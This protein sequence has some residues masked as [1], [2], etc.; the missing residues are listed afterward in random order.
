[1]SKH[2]QTLGLGQSIEAS[3]ADKIGKAIES[4]LAF[5]YKIDGA[6]VGQSGISVDL[7]GESG[8]L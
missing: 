6:V 1:M 3:G 8:A 5:A 2:L 7:S 4:H